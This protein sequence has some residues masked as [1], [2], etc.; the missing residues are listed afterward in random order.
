MLLEK[1]TVKKRQV[2]NRSDDFHYDLLPDEKEQSQSF[3]VVPFV[4]DHFVCFTHPLRWFHL[5]LVSNFTSYTK[6]EFD[7]AAWFAERD[8]RFE[9]KGDLTEIK[10]LIG[11]SQMEILSTL[12]T[13]DKKTDSTLIYYIGYDSEY[14]MRGYPDWLEVSMESDSVSEVSIIP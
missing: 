9:F 13:P 6:Q 11:L 3:G 12:G 4:P 5:R 2:T 14:F 8:N 7:K 1:N 10:R